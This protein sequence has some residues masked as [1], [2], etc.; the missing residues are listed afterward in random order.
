MQAKANSE[1]ELVKACMTELC[2]KAGFPDPDKMVQRD[3]EFLS[4]SIETKTGVLISLS[5]IKR[6]LNGQFSRLPQIATL[7]AISTYIGYQGWQQFKNSAV[8][9]PVAAISFN[10][11]NKEL[12]PQHRISIKP[13]SKFI[14]LGVFL[15]IAALG[16]LAML[17]LGKSKPDNFNK[18]SFSVAK[19]TSDQIPN[20]VVFNYNI[21]EV[22]ADSFFI[23]QSWDENRRVRIYKN[24]YTI[25][26]IYY[27]PGYHVAKL[28]A[29]DSIIKTMDVSI[30]T[31]RWFFYGKERVPNSPVKYIEVTQEEGL[32]TMTENNVTAAGLDLQKN[33]IYV[34][35]FFPSDIK[36]SVDNF[37]MNARVKVNNINNSQCSYLMCEIFCQR[38]FMYF[39]SSSKGCAGELHAQFVDKMLNGKT[40]DLSSFGTDTKEWQD[41][42]LTVINKKVTIK[43]N[44]REVYTTEY[45]QSGGLITGLGFISNGF[46]EVDFVSLKTLDGKIIY[47]NEF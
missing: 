33:N 2:A 8:A 36:Y 20:T 39:I 25:T 17:K 28:I 24:N 38:N 41:I 26:D 37:T 32:L 4:E 3:F 30:P 22:N 7:N 31:D 34:Q 45:N 27:E 35:T 23:Q 21:D 12:I 40:T 18:A 1:H 29:N 5:T 43:L 6:L 46:C 42:E 15:I 11:E 16:L 13:I 9:V 14:L 10:N 47:T 44:N 19:T